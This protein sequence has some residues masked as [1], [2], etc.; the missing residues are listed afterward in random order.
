MWSQF[1]GKIQLW[2]PPLLK[3]RKLRTAGIAVAGLVC[4]NLLLYAFLVG[5]WSIQ[6]SKLEKTVNE[7][8]K[9]NAT[10]MQFQKQKQLFN[11]AQ[12]GALTQ[13]DMPLLV[14]EFV[15]T[16][17]NQHLSVSSIKYDIPPRTGGEPA[18]L[19]FSFPAEGG[20]SDIKRF[21]YEI[22]S[23]HRTVGIKNIKLTAEKSK[24]KLDMKL[25]TY[26]K[27]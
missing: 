11:E 12:V 21:I 24:V 5:P 15:Q 6:F 9:R 14:K 18:M 10:A 13:K 19:A 2:V 23:S 16:A 20:Y 27:P 3:D 22:E 1:I 17:R 25:I 4:A 26:I 8:R 7:L